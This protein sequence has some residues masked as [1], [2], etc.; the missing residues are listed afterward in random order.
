MQKCAL[1]AWRHAS[2]ACSHSCP[3]LWLAICLQCRRSAQV[4]RCPGVPR[5]AQ[6]AAGTGCWQRTAGVCLLQSH[7]LSP[8][9]ART[10]RLGHAQVRSPA[11]RRQCVQVV[12]VDMLLDVA[13]AAADA[14]ALAAYSRT[15]CAEL[16]QQVSQAGSPAEAQQVRTAPTSTAGLRHSLSVAPPQFSADCMHR[17]GSVRDKHLRHKWSLPARTE[18]VAPDLGPSCR[19]CHACRD[20]C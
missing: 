16:G 9:A 1:C 15:L 13:G 12:T 11:S 3:H 10:G 2:L 18:R 17:Q 8:A 7:A 19:R 4:L 20:P 6:A 14:V 5:P